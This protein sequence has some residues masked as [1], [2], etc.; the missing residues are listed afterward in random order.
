MIDVMESKIS[1]PLKRQ[2]QFYSR[3]QRENTLNTI[4]VIAKKIKKIYV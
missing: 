2:K 3:K 4:L 1:S